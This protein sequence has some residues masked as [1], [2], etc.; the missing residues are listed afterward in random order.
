MR[1]VIDK[2]TFSIE[3]MNF[4]SENSTSYLDALMQI[5]EIYKLETQMIKKLINESLYSFLEEEAE[6]NN[7]IKKE[8]VTINDFF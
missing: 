7:N 3:V 6:K 5:T 2:E 8:T 4:A 1:K